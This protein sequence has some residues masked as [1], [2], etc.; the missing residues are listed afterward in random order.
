MYT[1]TYARIVSSSIPIA[2]TQ[3][4]HVKTMLS[5]EALLHPFLIILFFAD[6]QKNRV[7][8]SPQP[9]ILYILKNKKRRYR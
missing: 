3:Q 8:I 9:G 1:Y 6:Q 4:A 5:G 7:V 2:L